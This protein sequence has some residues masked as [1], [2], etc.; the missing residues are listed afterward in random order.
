M[1]SWARQHAWVQL[2][3]FP[4]PVGHP[5]SA[6][7][8][9]NVTEVTEVTV[10][11]CITSPQP[12]LFGICLQKLMHFEACCINAR[13]LLRVNVSSQW[14]MVRS[15][16]RPLHRRPHEVP[17]RYHPLARHHVDPGLARGRLCSPAHPPDVGEQRRSIYHHR[18]DRLRN[19]ARP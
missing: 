17:H 5:I 9:R 13:I 1:H 2:S 15:L 7:C 19:S 12:C 10:Q 3:F 6:G 8:T 18:T 4:F 11:K 14:L 16:V